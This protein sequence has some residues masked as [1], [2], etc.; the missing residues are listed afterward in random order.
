MSEQ[1]RLVMLRLH[2]MLWERNLEI[3]RLRARIE[4][5]E[6]ALRYYADDAYNGHNTN[7]SCAR[8]ALEVKP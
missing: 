7:G 6:T 3:E 8:A 2:D 1:Y 5:L 4:V